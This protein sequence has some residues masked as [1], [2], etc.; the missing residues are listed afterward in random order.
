MVLFLIISISLYVY[1]NSAITFSRGKLPTFSKSISASTEL[2]PNE[3]KSDLDYLIKTLKDAHFKS[4]DG[5]SEEQQTLIKSSYEKIKNT[6]K[7][8]D[9][10]F[11]ANEICCS[12]KDA[13]TSIY[14]TETKKDKCI[15]LP[16]IWLNDGLYVNGDENNLKRG[17]KIISIGNKNTDALLDEFKKITPAENDQW[18]KVMASRNIKGE[19]YLKHLGVIKNDCVE[20]K[21]NRSG[22]ILS[23]NIPL[24]EVK[25]NSTSKKDSKNPYYTILK[26]SSL[27]IF[28][29]NTC[30]ADSNYTN[31]LEEF[32]KYVKENNIKNI[33]VDLRNNTGGNSQVIEE[34]MSYLNIDKYKTFSSSI[35]F[36]KEA[37]DQRGYLRQSGYINY[38]A[39]IQKNS[40]VKDD[41]L[42]FKGNTYIL[43]SPI[44]FSSAN[45]FAVMFKDNS[46]GKIIGEPTGNAPS[47][48]GDIL[49]FQ[50]PNSKVCFTVSHKKFLRPDTNAKDVNSLS[51]D[52]LVYTTMNDINNKRDAQI[53]KLKEIIKK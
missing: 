41:S 12:F 2:T 51:P 7:V 10:Y 52:I 20:V 17:D 53:E 49:Q 46:L 48:Y 4:S 23:S 42:I 3:M 47:A 50:M 28:T 8:E 26:D 39:G 9:F 35:R 36:S 15:N 27:G 5:F 44:T 40:K 29:L 6:M 30:T 43:T 1:Y 19:T 16:L 14:I 22:Q 38:K 31:K 33:A 25:E 37:H 13:H 45:M 32:F 11:I 21:V 24:V 18:V 34:F